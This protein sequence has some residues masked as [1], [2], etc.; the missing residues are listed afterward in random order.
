[1]SS[2]HLLGLTAA[3]LLLSSQLGG[4]SKLFSF[5]QVCRGPLV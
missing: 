1:M 3:G 2:M 5:P 4:Y